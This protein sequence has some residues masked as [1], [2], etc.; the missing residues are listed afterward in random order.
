MAP[1]DRIV[2]DPAVMLEKP[3]IRAADAIALDERIQ[4]ESGDGP[5]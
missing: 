5:S 1:R 3:V 4:L 2:V